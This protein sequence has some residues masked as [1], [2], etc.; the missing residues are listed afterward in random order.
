MQ[1][2]FQDI[3]SLVRETRF[4]QGEVPTILETVLLQKDQFYKKKICGKIVD[5]CMAGAAP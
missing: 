2:F 4:P 5:Y 3:T 1:A